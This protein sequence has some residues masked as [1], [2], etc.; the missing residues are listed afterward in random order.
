MLLDLLEQMQRAHDKFGDQF[1]VPDVPARDS[2]GYGIRSV[3]AG[4]IF[5]REAC[6]VAFGREEGSWAH[7]AVEE[8]AE[9]IDAPDD[10]S[11]R[12]ELLQLAGVALRWVQAIDAR[13]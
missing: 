4:E 8:L 2:A 11:R 9:A 7:I 10:A 12:E 13:S 3:I 1:G 5:A 6:E